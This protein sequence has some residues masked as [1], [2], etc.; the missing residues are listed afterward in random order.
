MR[1]MPRHCLLSRPTH[2]E[3]IAVSAP[4]KSAAEDVSMPDALPDYE[5]HAEALPVEQTNPRVQQ[6]NAYQSSDA[7]F[8]D[9]ISPTAM[10][11]GASQPPAR[12]ES[13]TSVA[14]VGL[15]NQ[16]EDAISP[17]MPFVATDRPN[18]ADS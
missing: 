7:D 3:K 2:S 15:R 8:S 14:D 11:G 10:W 6:T 16:S 13:A 5:M 1:C 12:T 9:E 17:T 4:Q 18:A